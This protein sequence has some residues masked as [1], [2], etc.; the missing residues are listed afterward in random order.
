[1]QVRGSPLKEGGHQAVR[2]IML[3]T[4]DRGMLLFLLK[5]PGK[6]TEEV[7]FKLGLKE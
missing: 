5:G 3:E 2:V 7:I 4:A 6:T 1:M